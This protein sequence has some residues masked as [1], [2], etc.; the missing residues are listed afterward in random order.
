MRILYKTCGPVV[1]GKPIY[2]APRGR[3]IVE[4]TPWPAE[5]A[6]VVLLDDGTTVQVELGVPPNTPVH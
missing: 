3:L 2:T 4:C 6:L 1:K 5:N